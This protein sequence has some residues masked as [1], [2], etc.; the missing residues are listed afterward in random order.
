MLRAGTST[1]LNNGSEL[2]PDNMDKV[3]WYQGNS[4][5][6]THPVENK[7]KNSWGFYDMHGNV[8]EWC[9]DWYSSTY[10]ENAP[11]VDPTGPE[12]GGRRVLRG[13]SWNE[14]ME[15]CRSAVRYYFN[16]NERANYTGFRLALVPIL[17]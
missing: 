7:Q 9:S 10:Y 12:T 14:S 15:D 11:M 1:P 2:S 13:G 4:Y 6:Q 17:K 5:L 3:G 16:P 8:W